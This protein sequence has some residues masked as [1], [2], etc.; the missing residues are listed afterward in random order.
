MLPLFLPLNLTLF[1]PLGLSCSA[2]VR[3]VTDP[4][5]DDRVRVPVTVPG[6]GAA[7]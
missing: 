2:S 1:L 3:S 6:P 4:A 7:C 5:T